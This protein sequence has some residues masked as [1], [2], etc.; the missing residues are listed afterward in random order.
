MVNMS[1]MRR[2]FTHDAVPVT[3]VITVAI[4]LM[5]TKCKAV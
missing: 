1:S 2:I 5:I 3:S 4:K